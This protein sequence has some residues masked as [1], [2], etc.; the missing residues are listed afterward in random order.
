MGAMRASRVMP[1]RTAGVGMAPVRMPRP[2]LPAAARPVH[3]SHLTADDFPGALRTP[4]NRAAT[5][6]PEVA[7]AAIRAGRHRGDR[8]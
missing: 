5:V 2:S 8:L 7:A 6:T 4:E 1:T 3:S